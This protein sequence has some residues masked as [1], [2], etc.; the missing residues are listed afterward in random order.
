LAFF[1]LQTYSIL[2]KKGIRPSK[3]GAFGRYRLCQNAMGSPFLSPRKM[4]K[5]NSTRIFRATGMD[6]IM[7]HPDFLVDVWITAGLRQ[8]I[9]NNAY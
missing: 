8:M 6:L 3:A 5:D 4:A 2:K 1:F 7:T 9:R